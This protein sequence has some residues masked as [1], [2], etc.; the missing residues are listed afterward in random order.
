MS[1]LGVPTSV[2]DG[3]QM[4]AARRFPRAWVF[5]HLR[6]GVEWA[7]INLSPGS[8]ASRC[9]PRPCN[10]LREDECG[11]AEVSPSAAVGLN[12]RL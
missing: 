10:S 8:T 11:D 12:L 7:P 3:L 6:R 5:G 9:P 2:V 1:G 4:D